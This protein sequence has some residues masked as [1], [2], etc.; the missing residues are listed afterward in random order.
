MIKDQLYGTK[1]ARLILE[2]VER[3]LEG[4]E[5]INLDDESITVE[6][7]MPQQLTG[8][9]RATLGANCEDIH[10]KYLHTWGNL[11]L[12]GRNPEL[13]N[14]DFMRKKD[15]LKKSG[16]AMNRWIAEKESWGVAQILERGKWLASLAIKIWPGPNTASQS[17]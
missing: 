12:T 2:G 16:I 4:K 9:W 3:H 10:R 13:S 11:T 6:H 7:V 15:I 17:S 14:H 5:K 1:G 8:E